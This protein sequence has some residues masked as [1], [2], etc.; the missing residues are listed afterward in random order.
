[1]SRVSDALQRAALDRIQFRE[2][3]VDSRQNQQHE[4]IKTLD[5]FK[6]D[7]TEAPPAPSPKISASAE[8]S[9]EITARAKSWREKFEE[10]LFGWDLSR[11]NSHPLVAL[12]KDSAAAE[13]YRILREQVKN[14]RNGTGF[15]PISVTSPLKQEGKTM[16]AVNLAVTLAQGGD[17]QVLLI[18]ADLRNPD[19]HKYFGVQ[20][21]PGLADYLT[22]RSNGNLSSYVCATSFSGLEILPAGSSSDRAGELLAKERMKT[23]MEEIRTIY[24]ERQV[25]FDSPPVL[26]TSD[27][28][29]LAREVA[30]IIMVIRASKTPREYLKKAIDTLN[31]PKLMG[32]VLNGTQLGA[33]SKF[34]GKRT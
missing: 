5:A 10:L 26:A 32:I 18:D 30:G 15:H 31:S 8:A 28:L 16:V 2:R 33:A 20:R 29:V 9:P 1:M 23:L 17:E 34:Y 27:P 4:P 6:P 22:S 21:S 3:T 25:V 7:R 13:Q 19:V 12:E 11:L 24:P 14:L